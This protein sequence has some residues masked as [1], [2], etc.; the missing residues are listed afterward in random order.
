MLTKIK[1]LLNLKNIIIAILVVFVCIIGFRNWQLKRVKSKLTN[2]EINME[3][4]QLVE[5]LRVE[6]KSLPPDEKA[7]WGNKL[8]GGE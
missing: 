8:Y 1:P 3:Q 4:E 7:D 2:Q 5:K 6:I